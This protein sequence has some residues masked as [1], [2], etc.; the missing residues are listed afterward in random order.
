MGNLDDDA[1]LLGVR[2]AELADLVGMQPDDSLRT[3]GAAL[4]AGPAVF[5]AHHQLVLVPPWGWAE[6]SV[7]APFDYR[8]DAIGV[9]PPGI[10][11]RAD[12][13]HAHRLSFWNA[14]GLPLT[15]AG[16]GAAPAFAA[17]LLLGA[18]P[19]ATTASVAVGALVGAG[20]GVHLSRR[21]RR[22][23]VVTQRLEI[24]SSDSGAV[25]GLIRHLMRIRQIVA[26]FDDVV[27]P[28]VPLPTTSGPALE[29][30][31]SVQAMLLAVHRCIWQ[32]IAGEGVSAS[33]ALEVVGDLSGRVEAA[34]QD[35]FALHNASRLAD[36]DEPI[37]LPRLREVTAVGEL[38]RTVDSMD[39]AAAG[40]RLALRELRRLNGHDVPYPA[41]GEPAG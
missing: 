13:A 6:L 41:E 20:L 26:A 10:T 38:I 8:I 17:P 2:S 4:G 22:L 21:Y 24:A 37:Q 15:A 25:V 1:V 36:L 16:L 27:G 40:R 14:R 3:P 5:T 9:V 28:A 34:A 35:A 19:G 12:M 30:G 29:L 7:R 33:T 23:R 32:T 31:V 11:V 18:G 39:R